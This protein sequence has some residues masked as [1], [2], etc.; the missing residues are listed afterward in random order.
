MKLKRSIARIWWLAGLVIMADITASFFL[1]AN[2]MPVCLLTMLAGLIVIFRCDKK[3]RCPYC[4]EH[5]G[6]MPPM[7]K[8]AYK[9]CVRC[10]RFLV[11][12]DQPEPKNP[13][14]R[15]GKG[16]KKP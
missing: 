8:K 4:Q 3:L 10:D 2:L 13:V 16:E 7:N 11:F 6:I 9:K 12:D 15:P 1:P 5:I 14:Q